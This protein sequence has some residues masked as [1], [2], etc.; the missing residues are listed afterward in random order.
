MKSST[1]DHGLRSSGSVDDLFFRLGE[2]EVIFLAVTW[3]KKKKGN[4]Q[5]PVKTGENFLTI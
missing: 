3:R 1:F 4:Y 2:W 5:K